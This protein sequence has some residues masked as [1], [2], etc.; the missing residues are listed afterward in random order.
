MH[1]HAHTQINTRAHTH[2]RMLSYRKTYTLFTAS[3]RRTKICHDLTRAKFVFRFRRIF[4]IFGVWTREP[5][6]DASQTTENGNENKKCFFAP[7]N[8]NSNSSRRENTY[9]LC[10]QLVQ[11]RNVQCR[12]NKR[13]CSFFYSAF[14][15][16][17]KPFFSLLNRVHATL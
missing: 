17:F 8:S 15:S 11:R 3:P 13:L 5:H 9:G 7:L 2:T 10:S 12:A 4:F 1:S 6:H 16:L 14:L